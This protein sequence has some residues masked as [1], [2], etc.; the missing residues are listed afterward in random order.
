MRLCSSTRDDGAHAGRR[1]RAAPP[2]PA[3]RRCAGAGPPRRSPRRASCACA[4]SAICAVMPVVTSRASPPPRIRIPAPDAAG[5]RRV[6]DDRVPALA[7]A[8][9]DR[10][11]PVE[12]L[13][14]RAGASPRRRRG[15]GSSCRGSRASAPGRRRR[16][17]SARAARRRRRRRCRRG[18]SGSRCI[19]ASS[20]D[21]LVAAAREEDRDRVQVGDPAVHRQAGHDPDD[22]RL[23]DPLHEKAP[24]DLLR[25]SRRSVP[26]P[27]SE[28]KKSTRSSR[29][30][31]S[32]IVV[33]AGLPHRAHPASSSRLEAL[34]ARR[35]RSC[36]CGAS[37]GLPSQRAIPRPLTVWQMI[38]VGLARRERRRPAARGAARRRSCPSTSRAAKPKLRHLAAKRLQVEDLGRRGRSTASCCSPR[39]RSGARAGAWRRRAPPPRPSPRRTRRRRAARRCGSRGRRACRAARSRPRPAA[40]G[41]ATRSRPRRPGPCRPAGGRRAASPGAQKVAR[42]SRGKK[43]LLRQHG[44]RAPGSRAP[45]SG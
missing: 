30:A 6:A 42:C 8:D 36:S 45:C 15:R 20:S 25:G 18:A 9:V 22:V 12:R 10:P 43:P 32:W 37:R 35:R 3:A 7:E 38:A 31:S 29:R 21:L 40:R 2:R 34:R 16:G 28:P 39:A 27:M 13:R 4:A 41:R 17:A 33:E 1:P 24:R 11:L 19:A 26:A 44:R 5:Q 23:G 14:R